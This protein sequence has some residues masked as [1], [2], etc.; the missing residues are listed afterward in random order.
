MQIDSSHYENRTAKEIYKSNSF[1]K[2]IDKEEM[3][4]SYAQEIKDIVKRDAANGVYM[5][6]DYIAIQNKYVSKVAPDRARAISL[7]S[8]KLNAVHQKT[9]KGYWLKMLGEPYEASITVGEY[10]KTAHVYDKN[11]EKIA[12]YSSITGWTPNP[13]KVEQQFWM[14]ASHM[15]SQMFDEAK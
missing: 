4:E 15:Y 5:S 14:T 8:Q 1:K 11:G 12:D 7:V 6:E 3:F 13:T 10:M 9:Y 2:K